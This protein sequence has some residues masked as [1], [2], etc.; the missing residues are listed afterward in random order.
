[1]CSWT[2]TTVVEYFN[3]RGRDVFG[4]GCD[5]KKAFDMCD[6]CYLFTDLRE[7]GVS[8]IFLRLMIYMYEEQHCD[9][10]WNGNFSERF[11]VTNGIRQG[12]KISPL[13]FCVYVDELIKL[14]RRLC[15]GCHVEGV[16]Y[17]CLF[18]ADDLFLLSPTR[19]GLQEM[20][21]ASEKYMSK[22]NL[23]FSTN[24]D[25]AKSKTK[26]IIFSKRRVDTSNVVP[27]MLN[28]QP[29]PYVDKM[30]HLGNWLQTNNSMSIDCNV[31]RSRFIGKVNSLYQEF[32]FST[33]DVKSKLLSV[34]C[35]SFYGSCLYDLYG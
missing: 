2:L 16:F 20:I 9:V 28:N 19:E 8:P 6:W 26:A 13:C 3:N 15:I 30:L 32:Y 1:M 29:L 21:N 18:Y 5:M 24:P 35:T 10:R 25:P 23:I 22:R 14:L 31:K 17:G 12:S 27:I 7:K 11:P 33:P 34:Y 4:A